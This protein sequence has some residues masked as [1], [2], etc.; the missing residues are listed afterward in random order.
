MKALRRSRGVLR[1]SL[2][3]LKYLVLV[4]SVALA[5]AVS[6]VRFGLN[7]LPEAHARLE[8]EIGRALGAPVRFRQVRAHL[9]GLRPHLGLEDA[10]ILDGPAIN[11]VLAVRSLELSLDPLALLGGRLRLTRVTAIGVELTVYRDDTGRW[12]LRGLRGGDEPPL[13]LL[14]EGR[15]ELLDSRV[16]VV[17]GAGEPLQLERLS[18]RIHNAADRHRLGLHAQDAVG[19]LRL[20]AQL[21]GD[22]A[23][24]AS[25]AGRLYLEASGLDLAR[26][27]RLL[28]GAG[29]PLAGGHGGVRLWADVGP[30][31]TPH[32]AY[33]RLQLAD[34]SVA[35]GPA[36]TEPLAA[37]RL[38]VRLEWWRSGA[39]WRLLA[40]S[41][42]LRLDGTEWPELQADLRSA[43]ANP[44]RQGFDLAMSHLELEGARKLVRQLLPQGVRVLP[45]GAAPTGRLRGLRLVHAPSAAM[46]GRWKF[47]AEFQALGLERPWRGVPAFAG[48]DGKICGSEGA[49]RI[50]ARLSGQRV[51]TG[52]LLRWPVERLSL[53]GQMAWQRT[54][55]QWRFHAERLAVSNPDLAADLG[56]ELIVPRDSTRSM[57]IALEAAIARVDLARLHRY[58]P[59]D[60]LSPW[61]VHF[62][63]EGLK[64]GRVRDGRVVLRGP[65]RDYPFLEGQG[66]LLAE[67][68]LQNLSLSYDPEWPP[69]IGARGVFRLQNGH[70]RIELQGGKVLEMPL[71]Q[72][73]SDV[74]HIG[75]SRHNAITVEADGTWPQLLATLAE[76]PVAGTVRQLREH[77]EVTGG[78]R[79]SVK[80][81]APRGDSGDRH[82]LDWTVRS[83]DAQ[84]RM[85]AIGLS[86]EQVT[87]ELR[88]GAQGS[89][90]QNL[91]AQL[92]GR[93]V[94]VDIK[95]TARA[96]TVRLQ[97]RQR[98]TDFGRLF[99]GRLWA[100]TRGDADLEATLEIPANTPGLRFALQSDLEGADLD[101]PPPFGKK[102]A[103]RRRLE[104]SLEFAG[105]PLLP[106]RIDYA[107]I[108]RSYLR[109]A[110]HEDGSRRFQGMDVVLGG[111][112]P[113]IGRSQGV[114]VQGELERLKIEDWAGF[115]GGE[116][117]AGSRD[118]L[119]ELNLRVG[120]LE[121]GGEDWGW[122]RIGYQS[123]T[124][125]GQVRLLGQ[126]LG[127]VVEWV[128]AGPTG[129]DLE[130]HLHHLS[131]PKVRREI[132]GEVKRADRARLKSRGLS[133]LD[134]KIERLFWRDVLLG[135]LDFAMVQRPTGMRIER[136]DLA[137]STHRMHMTGDWFDGPG[138]SRTSLDGE[139]QIANL[140]LLLDRFGL[141]GRI[142]DT[143]SHVK[144]AL[145]WPGAPQ[146]LALGTLDGALD[147]DFGRG[148]LPQVEPGIGR[149]LGL[150]DAGSIVRRLALDF[151]DV[152]GEGLAYDGIKGRVAI[153]DGVASTERIQINGPSARITLAGSADLDS[154]RLDQT[155]HVAART[156][157][158]LPIA[159]AIVGG[160]AVGAAVL[161]A[162]QLIG[163]QLD[164]V[165]GSSYQ[166]AGT[167]D[168]PKLTRIY[169]DNPI[170]YVERGVSD[171][172][173]AIGD[174]FRG[175]PPTQTEP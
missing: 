40:H 107:G 11:P 51:D 104:L 172:T 150:F 123:R 164:R 167:F 118:Q 152:F 19:R 28:S 126:N 52:G 160:P 64:G 13:W 89:T 162:Q 27:R 127:G 77:L 103:E 114:Y 112:Q 111:A 82:Q 55:E 129:T 69:L 157:V 121:L 144:F 49:G 26:W 3:L 134:L 67:L 165:T 15:Y 43:G 58:L 74:P 61:T 98:L 12:R 70:R 131:L 173:G 72:V 22:A 171:L 10:A 96:T 174:V 73:I 105:Q 159:G 151:R 7:A 94:S 137:G 47:C 158:A 54:A 146:E 76:S 145:N 23:Q 50:E 86:F 93:P 108:F 138:L 17:D 92:F 116:R 21:R 9:L 59:V 38:S 101:L 36:G 175:T 135:A 24:P 33:A 62:I 29:V 155:L 117:S 71:K 125:G 143:P 60:H 45:D 115:L 65:L 153:A 122:A 30:G 161:A 85:P 32:W 124:S 8:A 91:Q 130:V 154:Q 25:L 147:L 156:S 5:M 1:I 102:A 109:L 81:L 132:I 14:R 128:G 100:L 169:A 166:V 83:S 88:K 120:A 99:P 16:M 139:V 57:E 78:A 170:G 75:R 48:L 66:T 90:A 106:V 41:A 2:A 31:A 133:R 20:L 119:R 68:P 63:D 42:A 37:E 113:R 148:Q 46:G 87:G 95:P 142:E 39:G 149:A 163:R 79:L 44:V 141:S 35:T 53:R 18:I 84:V 140:G 110:R 6:L 97:T 56:L 34:A 4:L 136:L 168:N 80:L